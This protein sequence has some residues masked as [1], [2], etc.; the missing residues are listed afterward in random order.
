MNQEMRADHSHERRQHE[1][2]EGRLLIKE[3]K[4]VVAGGL[5]MSKHR[6]EGKIQTR[7]ELP[8][9]LLFT[10]KWRGTGSVN[11]RVLVNHS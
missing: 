6:N 2:I 5:R 9:T 4:H 7:M 1:S 11:S 8:L 3:T 10:R